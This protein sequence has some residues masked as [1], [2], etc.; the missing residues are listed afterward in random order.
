MLVPDE[1]R[2]GVVFVYFSQGGERKPAGTAFFVADALPEELESTWSCLW[3]A[4]HVI[5]A[6]AKHGDDGNVH[7]RLNTRD[8]G[9][10]W[11]SAPIREWIQPDPTL[12]MVF[13]AWNYRPDDNIDLRAWSL[14]HG[15]VATDETIRREA[16]GIGDEVF[17]VG[18]FRHHLGTAQ[19]EPI[20]RVG[21]IAAIPTEG[22]QTADYGKM[23]AVLIEAR[24]IGGLSGCP[25]FVHM[26]FARPRDGQVER[27]GRADPF[28]LLGVMHGHWRATDTDL[29]VSDTGERINSG[30][31]IVVPVENIMRALAPFRDEVMEVRRDVNRQ[32]DAAI[33]DAVEQLSEFE[34]FENL[35]RRLLAVSKS[36]LDDKRN[37]DT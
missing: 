4:H 37:Q 34:Q 11:R 31:G 17:M 23:P 22:A 6:I 14:A 30:I 27:A 9:T 21:N 3:S 29:P 8:G 19:N 24:S 32:R 20:I 25:V 15:A 33:P 28:F 7:L 16:I 26:G 35:T 1:I 36:E 18:L 10:L 5:A 12:D 13:H 2:K